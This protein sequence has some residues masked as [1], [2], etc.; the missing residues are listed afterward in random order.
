[1]KLLEAYNPAEVRACGRMV[2]AI[3]AA[4]GAAEDILGYA[5]YA[6]TNATNPRLSM[7]RLVLQRPQHESVTKK[8]LLGA[9]GPKIL[10]EWL[11][12]TKDLVKFELELNEIRSFVSL[13]RKKELNSTNFGPLRP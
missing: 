12:I 10:R 8:E 11:K 3:Q 5:A 2:K 9:L 1:M 4:G 6:E 7:L 13:E